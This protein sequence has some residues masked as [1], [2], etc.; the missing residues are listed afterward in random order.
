MHKSSTMSLKRPLLVSIFCTIGIT[1][2]VTHAHARGPHGG[3]GGNSHED[4]RQSYNKG[5]APQRNAPRRDGPSTQSRAYDNANGWFIPNQTRGPERSQTR[6]DA[7]TPLY[8][9]APSRST[10]PMRGSVDP[11][12]TTRER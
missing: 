1:L 7:P 12:L 10:E 11:R 3:Q 8:Q 2:A 6:R 4:M 9:Q 5:N